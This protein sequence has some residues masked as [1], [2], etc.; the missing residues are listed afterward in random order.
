MLKSAGLG[1]L[2]LLISTGITVALTAVIWLIFVEQLLSARRPPVPKRGL[3]SLAL[4][5]FLFWADHLV[6]EGHAFRVV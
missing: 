2:G 5:P 3:A 1:L 4:G 6:F